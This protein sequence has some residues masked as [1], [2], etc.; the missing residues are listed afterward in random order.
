MRRIAIAFGCLALASSAHGAE[1]PYWRGPHGNNVSTETG[2]PSAW[3][4]DGQNQVWRDATWIGRSTPA[5]FDGRACASGRAGGRLETVACWDARDGRK[6][7]ERRF[8]VYN[9]TIP[10]TRVGWAS[11]TGDPETGHLY[12][13][14]GDGHLFCLDREGK[15]VWE[16]RLG[17]ELGRVSGYGGRTHTVL[18]DEDRVLLSVVGAAFGDLAAL[19]QR[20]VAMDKRDGR[21]LWINTPNNV[22]VEDF[23]NQS[24]AIVAELGGRRLV[25]GGGADGWLY[26]I[27]SRT[28]ESV[29][30]FHFSQKS[31]NAP[32]TV[33]GTTVYAVSDG[34][35]VDESFLGQ[36]V[37]IN[38]IGSGDI[39][40]TNRLW[41]TDAIMA[42]FAAPV[43]DAASDRL[44]VVDN[45]ANLYA[46]D[47]KTGRKLYEANVGTVGRGTPLLADGKLYVTEVNGTLAI[48][49]PHA[50]R[51]EMLDT[52]R[53]TMAEGRQTELWGSIA[54]AYG[55]LY[56]MAEDGV[57]C[58]GDP[59]KPFGG[60][61]PG[62]GPAPAAKPITAAAGEPASILLV[63]AEA[64]IRSGDELAFEIHAFDAKGNRLGTLPAASATF[65]LEG[66][67]GGVA[68]GRFR[69]D[70]AAGAQ[71][72]RIKVGAGGKEA[73]SRVRVYPPLP[74][75]ED[76]EA[77]KVP[78]HWVSAGR[79]SIGEAPEGKTL[80]KAPA[81][82]G[83][84]RSTAL[85]GPAD[86]RGYTIEV[87][88][89]GQ[90]RGRRS[91]DIGLVNA[92]Y[93]LDLQG[94]HQRLQVRSWASE[95]EFSKQ[96]DF[97]W[98]FDT[99]YRMKLRVDQQGGTALVR[100]KVWKKGDPEPEAWT[101]SYDDPSG[102][103]AGAPGVYADSPT[104]VDMDNLK[105]VVNR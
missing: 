67:K 13:Q 52:D 104:D 82:V 20:Y 87:E 64:Q 73:V 36:I 42:G 4:R 2:L 24:N 61:A 22:N 17:E 76:F 54:A 30:R 91:P 31:L 46:L 3:T 77:G 6:L 58:V 16:R 39:T 40:A 103:A 72:G 55:R 68:N 57:Y 35:P 15:T 66:L 98:E 51:F 26:A 41:H 38:G 88:L 78:S 9:T 27:D 5:V 34:E 11:V 47:A 74:W 50:D 62:K 85:I 94:N 81:P 49:K 37:A 7:W 56:F 33:V 93:T 105:V 10:Y 48:V 99:W 80:H 86:M 60:P 53:L 95:L 14:N 71:G 59:Q 84:N 100:G 96:I 28:G 21:V 90:K 92:G 45:S 12:A 25:I 29:W 18:I 8:P 65:T 89:K 75:S 32:V 1:W 44:Y 70:A 63:P 19:R 97:A 69:A 83:L 102:I 101:I 43:H 79:F 23:N